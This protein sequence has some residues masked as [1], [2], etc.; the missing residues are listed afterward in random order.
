MNLRAYKSLEWE[1]FLEI[2]LSELESLEVS[3]M[4]IF[5]GGNFKWVG[6]KGIFFRE[7]L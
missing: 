2:I 6:D 7:L 5:F 1:Y 3:R 4:R